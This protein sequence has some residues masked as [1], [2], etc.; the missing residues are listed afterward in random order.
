M[1]PT[2]LLRSQLMA[3]SDLIIRQART[4]GKAYNLPDT[5]TSDELI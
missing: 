5:D 1:E 3:L 2:S 4:T